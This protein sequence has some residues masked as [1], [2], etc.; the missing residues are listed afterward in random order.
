MMPETYHTLLRLLREIEDRNLGLNR[1][2]Q[3]CFSHVC[4]TAL[5][6]LNMTD[7]TTM[8]TYTVARMFAT[9]YWNEVI[10]PTLEKVREFIERYSE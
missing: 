10:Y 2:L 6:A 5:E 8:L 3:I 7:N 4:A 1:L 9:D